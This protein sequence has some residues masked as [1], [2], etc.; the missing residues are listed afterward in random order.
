LG[1]GIHAIEVAGAEE[2]AKGVATGQAVKDY[3]DLSKI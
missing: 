1:A 2:E 3:I